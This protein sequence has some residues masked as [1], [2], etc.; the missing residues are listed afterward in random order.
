MRNTAFLTCLILAVL[1]MTA[2]SAS[3]QWNKRGDTG[4]LGVSFAYGGDPDGV[5]LEYTTDKYVVDAL[6]FNDDFRDSDITGIEL[7]WKTGENGASRNSLVA[8]VAYYNDDPDVGVDDTGIGWWAGM[9]DFSGG[10]GMFYQ[11]RYIF[12]GPLEGT[13]GLLGWRF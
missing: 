3:A 10:G 8:G 2:I 4:S 5:R 7:G 13:Q 1:V 12:N 6:Y 9:G 11:L